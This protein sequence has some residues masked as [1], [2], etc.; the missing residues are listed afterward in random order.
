MGLARAIFILATC[1]IVFVSGVIF[2]AYGALPKELVTSITEVLQEWATL[3][4]TRP[5]H[6]LQRARH[7]GDGITRHEVSEDDDALIFLSG[8]FKDTNEL[9]LIRRDGTILARWPVGFSQIFIVS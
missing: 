1:A 2:G 4:K 6:Y 3:M 8:F 9:R 7:N 5:E